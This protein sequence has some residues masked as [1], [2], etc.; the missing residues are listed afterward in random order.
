MLIIF[1]KASICRSSV[2]SLETHDPSSAVER[3]GFDLVH[4]KMGFDCKVF[5]L[6]FCAIETHIHTLRWR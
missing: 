5:G 2:R 3:S 4:K 6:F 1:N